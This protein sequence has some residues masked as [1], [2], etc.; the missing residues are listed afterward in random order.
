MWFQTGQLLYPPV[1]SVT[2]TR[3]SCCTLDKPF[4]TTKYHC[5]VDIVAMHS[6][7]WKFLPR[8]IYYANCTRL[9]IWL[10]ANPND[11][12]CELVT[13]QSSSVVKLAVRISA[14]FHIALFLES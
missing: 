1:N 8:F 11:H 7:L 13:L 14:S 9:H 12:S 10:P 3:Y 2:Y 4:S 5:V 6:L